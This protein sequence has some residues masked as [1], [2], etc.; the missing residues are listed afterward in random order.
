MCLAAPAANSGDEPLEY[1]LQ[2]VTEPWSPGHAPSWA[3]PESL[4]MFAHMLICSY[5]SETWLGEVEEAYVTTQL[6]YWSVCLSIRAPCCV[7]SKN[8][9]VGCSLSASL[10]AT[11]VRD[12][13]GG[14][15]DDLQPAAQVRAP[16]AWQR[17][18][19]AGLH[20]SECNGAEVAGCICVMRLHM[21]QW[22]GPW[23]ELITWVFGL[24]SLPPNS[25]P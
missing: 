22:L 2:L 20:E 24:D 16:Q 6:I 17:G 4:E 18:S 13:G 3:V 19:G 15:S 25:F 12:D 7:C 1:Y 9:L 14:A 8:Q 21:R 10:V 11:G 23:L 5:C